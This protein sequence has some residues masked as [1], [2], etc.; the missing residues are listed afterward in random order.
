MPPAGTV[1]V[2]GVALRTVPLLPAGMKRW[3]KRRATL[4]VLVTQTFVL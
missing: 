1:R 4:L 2:S 3:V